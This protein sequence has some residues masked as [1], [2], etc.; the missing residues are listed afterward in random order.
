MLKR[1][2]NVLYFNQYVRNNQTY[3]KFVKDADSL[4]ISSKSY[5]EKA[6]SHYIVINYLDGKKVREQRVFNHLR[7]DITDK[8][9]LPNPKKRILLFVNGYRPT[10]NGN[11]FES[12]FD[13]IMKKGLEHE[14]SNNLIYDND[15]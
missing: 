9:S 1:R 6:E 15:R 13:S 3:F 7:L 11:S 5:A 2:K 10:A 8:I 4:L 14:N 12:T